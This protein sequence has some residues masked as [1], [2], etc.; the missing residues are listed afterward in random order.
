M[1]DPQLLNDRLLVESLRSLERRGVVVVEPEAD[2][3]ARRLESTDVEARLA[4]RAKSASQ[5]GR[6]V[7]RRAAAFRWLRAKASSAVT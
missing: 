2:A 1:A 4:T 3:A 6:L 7:A 5:P